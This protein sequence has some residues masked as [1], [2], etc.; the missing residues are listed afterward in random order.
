MASDGVPAMTGDIDRV[1]GRI[2][3]HISPRMMADYGRAVIVPIHRSG[4][5]AQEFCELGARAEVAA[6]FERSFYLRSG[7]MFICVGEPAVGNGPLTLVADIESSFRLSD[8]GLHSRQSAVISNR[9]I[10]VR[11]WVQFT[12]DRCE[13]WRPPCWPAFQSPI[14]MTRTCVAI[15]R[16]AAVEAPE[17]GFGR[18][19]FCPHERATHRMPLTRLARTRIASF[20]SWLSRALTTKHAP[21]TAPT[22][23]LRG[24]VGLGPG[25][26]PSGDDFLLGVLA[27]LDALEERKIHGAL[28]AAITDVAPALTSPL[29]HCFLRTAAAG[30]VGEYLHRAVSSVITG[31]VDAALAA[32]RKIGHSSGWDMMAGI[33]T[34]LQIVAAARLKP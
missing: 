26:T 31:N 9:R 7:D 34:A 22:E 15:A 3:R 20:E 21:V 1:Y 2:E 8:L 23:P 13:L 6:V 30:H 4:V 33:A 28:A 11:D 12:F 27:L 29:S 32:V 19:F 25:L 14:A 18:E 24:L 16:R 5:L 17:E 10:T